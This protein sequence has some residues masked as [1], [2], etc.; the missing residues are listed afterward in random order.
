[1][2]IH[3]GPP[4]L[5]SAQ[6]YL[7]THC[8]G[9]AARS[10]MQT[11]TFHWPAISSK[12]VKHAMPSPAGEHRGTSAANSFLALMFISVLPIRHFRLQ[13][14]GLEFRPDGILMP[15]RFIGHSHCICVPAV[16]VEQKM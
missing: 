8:F 15:R 13:G 3:Q 16:H 10:E 11:H 5:V 14:L 7:R 6:R 9:H 1:M 12:N 2:Q 4:E